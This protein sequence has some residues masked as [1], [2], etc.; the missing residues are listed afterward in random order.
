MPATT[1][2]GMLGPEQLRGIDRLLLEYL[3]EGRVTP[4]Y[5]QRRITD[6]QGRKYSRG[7]IQERLARLVEHN[8]AENCYGCG[9]YELVDDPREVDG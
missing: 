6:E 7:Y 5:C 3:L 9:L 1:D 4:A 2:S 8:H